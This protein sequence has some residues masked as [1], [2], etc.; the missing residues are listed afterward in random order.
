MARILMVSSEAT[1][2]AKPAGWRCRCRAAAALQQTGDEVAVGMP[3]MADPVGFAGVRL[4]QSAPLRRT[5]SMERGYPDRI[6]KGVRFYFVEHP[7]LLDREGLYAQRAL[8]T[9]TTPAVRRALAGR[10]RRAQ[11][12]LNLT[13]SIP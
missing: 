7:V 5:P 11:T 4:R 12:L 10:A 9:G 6:E 8:I 1:P 2:F 13:S 3:G